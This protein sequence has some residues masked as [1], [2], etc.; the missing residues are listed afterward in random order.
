MSDDPTPADAPEQKENPLEKRLQSILGRTEELSKNDAQRGAEIGE[1][2][3]LLTDLSRKIES[4]PSNASAPS[5]NVP[6]DPFSG[7]PA[8]SAQTPTDLQSAVNSAVQEALKPLTEDAAA[9]Q[10]KLS[11]HRDSFAKVV[12][13]NPVFADPSSEERRLFDQI[14]G[15]RAD[16]QQLDDAPALIAEIVN[17]L[18]VDRRTEENRLDLAKTRATLPSAGAGTA[19]G[20]FGDRTP[21]EITEMYE[22]FMEKHKY[23]DISAQDLGDYINLA[24]AKAH[25]DAGL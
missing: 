8:A 3:S 12:D 15:S 18:S 22:A 7:G 11:K 19:T 21:D 1:I 16:L 5:A 17:G 24:T 25:I 9:Q 2:K 4:A 23:K 20:R 10:Q 6:T 13:R 14:Y